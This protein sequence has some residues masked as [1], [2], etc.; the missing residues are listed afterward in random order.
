MFYIH[1][2]KRIIKSYM[3]VG[4][5]KILQSSTEVLST[6]VP[7]TVGGVIGTSVV[8]S[9]IYELS[10]KGT[11]AIIVANTEIT[12][13]PLEIENSLLKSEIASL[14]ERVAILEEPSL[15]HKI[16]S[17]IGTIHDTVSNW[18]GWASK[19]PQPTVEQQP[20]LLPTE[21]KQA[22]PSKEGVEETLAFSLVPENSSTLFRVSYLIFGL[23][24][25]YYPL[26]HSFLGKLFSKK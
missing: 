6:K 12:P 5:K 20:P 17:V 14:K 19:R 13:S 15:G 10:K 3:K 2:Y 26:L 11:E 22:L 9:G 8:A 1:T 21:K 4:L 23:Y 24:M 16:D 18:I 7:P 25:I